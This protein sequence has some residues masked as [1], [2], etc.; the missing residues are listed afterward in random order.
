MSDE[1]V[2][3]MHYLT[4][5]DN[6]KKENECKMAADP[7][8]KKVFDEQMFSGNDIKIESYLK[9]IEHYF[10]C[11]NY[12]RAHERLSDAIKLR[13]INQITSA[14]MDLQLKVRRMNS[15]EYSDF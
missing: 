14:M 9:A 6:L 1:K 2:E 15:T 13:R 11:D 7:L 10:E 8:D 4:K 12:G 3:T 5:V